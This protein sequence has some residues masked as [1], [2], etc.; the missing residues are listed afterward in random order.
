MLG[1][2]QIARSISLLIVYKKT[3]KYLYI[4]YNKANLEEFAYL[5]ECIYVYIYCSL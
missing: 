3:N 1:I 5:K 2:G 4:C